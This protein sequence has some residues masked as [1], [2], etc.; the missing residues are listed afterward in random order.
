[1]YYMGYPV[2]QN[3]ATST[4][5]NRINK[6]KHIPYILFDFDQ[7]LRD[8]SLLFQTYLIS[9]PHLKKCSREIEKILDYFGKFWT[10]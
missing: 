8:V 5:I 7:Q 1:M 6:L 3:W 9:K 10:V 4:V 2:A